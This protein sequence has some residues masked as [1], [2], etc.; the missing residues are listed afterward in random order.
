MNLSINERLEQAAPNVDVIIYTFISKGTHQVALNLPKK[1]GQFD[2]NFGKI[3]Y[4]E[5]F[6]E[7]KKFT[8]DAPN[9]FQRSG[10]KEIYWT[11]GGTSEDKITAT[12]HIENIELINFA[13]NPILE[14]KLSKNP[15]DMSGKLPY[16]EILVVSLKKELQYYLP[17]KGNLPFGTH[18]INLLTN[19]TNPPTV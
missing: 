11:A 5:V 12:F 19:P 17:V 8:K 14:V 6:F 16:L 13:S 7:V 4:S 15:F 2:P 10:S 9:I 1:S 3:M 18:S